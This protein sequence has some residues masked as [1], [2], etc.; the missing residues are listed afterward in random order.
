M[1]NFENQC[2]IILAFKRV[3]SVVGK[4]GLAQGILAGE[5]QEVPALIA[6]GT[7]VVTA[8]TTFATEN[9][10]MS[11]LFQVQ[12]VSALATVVGKDGLAQGILVGEVQ[13]VPAL[14]AE[15]TLVVTA[16][17]TFATEKGSMSLLF[18]AQQVPAMILQ[19]YITSISRFLYCNTQEVP[20]QNEVFQFMTYSIGPECLE[21]RRLS[22]T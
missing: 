7:L 17:T 19:R 4:D 20:P 14:I 5:V 16:G 12:Q 18:Q 6:E 13:E 10:S 11:A 9:G 1:V 2:L 22:L 8:G 21:R 3:A 15:G